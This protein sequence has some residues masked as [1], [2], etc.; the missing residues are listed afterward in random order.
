MKKN[1]VEQSEL[2][3]N[4]IG[5]LAGSGNSAKLKYLAKTFKDQNHVNVLI[6]SE[7]VF[8]QLSKDKENATLFNHVL[9]YSENKDDIKNFLRNL[10]EVVNTV[11]NQDKICIYVYGVLTNANLV[12]IVSESSDL[13]EKR[14]IKLFYTLQSIAH[15]K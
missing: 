1:N 3:V 10:R 4:I 12:E 14:D 11:E 5:G 2:Q 6:D 9:S 8:Q 7:G 13:A 15:M